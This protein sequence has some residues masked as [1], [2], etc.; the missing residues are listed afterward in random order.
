MISAG[1]LRKGITFELD[2]Q[3]Y[4]VIDFLH[5][6]PGKGAAFVRTKLRNVISGGVTETTFN[7]TAK[8][9]DVVIERKEMQYLYSDGTLYYFMDQE[10]YEQIPLSYEQVESA[11]KFLKENMFAVIKFYKGAA[12][13]VE[14]PNFVE[15]VITET[16]PGFK[17]NTAT[18]TLKPATLETG[19]V[20]QVPLFVN[21]GETIKIDTRTGEYMERVK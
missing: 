1:E 8:L 19:A 18:N 4:T 10:T 21:E 9:Q 13:S 12:F 16:D 17:G 2:G 6:K 5:V 14:A 7:P 11:I 15:L 3:V 20:V